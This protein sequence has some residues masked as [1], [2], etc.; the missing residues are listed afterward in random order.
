LVLLAAEFEGQRPPGESIVP[1]VRTPDISI[2]RFD[3]PTVRWIVSLSTAR[4][5]PREDAVPEGEQLR[6]R[7]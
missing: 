5:L 3:Q 1:D 7:T 6:A 4:S 2:D